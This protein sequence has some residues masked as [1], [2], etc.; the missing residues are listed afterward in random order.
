MDMFNQFGGPALWNR[1]LCLCLHQQH[2]TWVSVQ[3]LAIPLP[4]R[5]PAK[6]LRKKCENVRS[7][8]TPT[9]TQETWMRLLAPASSLAQV[10][11]Y[12]HFGSEPA[13]GIV[14]SISAFQIHK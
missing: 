2:P 5:L 13:G 12:S 11:R 9:V 1:G 3:V 4:I 8:W 6:C 14:L 7:A 10:G